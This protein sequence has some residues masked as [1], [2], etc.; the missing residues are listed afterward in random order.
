METEAK[1]ALATL[2]VGMVR[3]TLVTILGAAVLQGEEWVKVW[4]EGGRGTVL[5]A[6]TEAAA[7]MEPAAMEAA[8]MEVEAMVAVEMEA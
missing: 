8:V 5:Q 2:V 6:E 7:V 4:M 1:A 3:A